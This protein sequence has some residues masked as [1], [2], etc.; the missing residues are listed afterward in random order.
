MQPE[1]D[2]RQQRRRTR[3]R[4]MLI[5]A[6]RRVM[7]EKGVD[8][9][10]LRDIASAADLAL[11]TFYNHFD[12]KDAVVDA[13]VDEAVE[14]LG[15][16]LDRLTADMTDPAEVFAVSFRHTLRSVEHDPVWGWFVVRVQRAGDKLGAHLGH[17]ATRDIERG[18]ASGRFVR[19]RL[20]PFLIATQGMLE[21]MMRAKLDGRSRRGDDTE[22]AAYTLI[23]LGVAADE[24]H[25]IAAR[26]LP[27]VVG[28]QT[29]GESK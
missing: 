16:G 9:T 24:A 27:Q 13:I 1:V 3:T 18:F 25:E 29:R 14:R 17:R 8:A 19:I 21:S 5:D 20:R 26:P 6:A 22:L 2:S 10:S 7:S 23:L 11:G 4:A 28:R 15:E 12:S